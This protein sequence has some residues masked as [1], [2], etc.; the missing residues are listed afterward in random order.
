V[1]R[2]EVSGIAEIAVIAVIAEIGKTKLMPDKLWALK[3][4]ISNSCRLKADL[5][6]KSFCRREPN[7]VA[8][9]L[10]TRTDRPSQNEA[11]NGRTN[12]AVKNL[13]Q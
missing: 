6:K 12:K 7:F 1:Y 8:D 4:S 10:L 11:G 9:V 5:L 2:T 13:E 3:R